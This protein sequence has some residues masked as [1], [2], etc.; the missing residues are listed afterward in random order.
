M[1]GKE[2]SQNQP[3]REDSDLDL[4]S[5]S[6]SMRSTQSGFSEVGE[7]PV[8][9]DSSP[10]YENLISAATLVA[11]P[12]SSPQPTPVPAAAQAPAKRKLPQLPH[13]HD[14]RRTRKD[15]YIGE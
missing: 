12:K 11:P 8:P 2:S 5:M 9:A 7:F 13:P 10:T 4:K 6:S 15:G 3:V 14:T 1:G